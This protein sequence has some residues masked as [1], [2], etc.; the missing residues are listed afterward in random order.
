MIFGRCRCNCSSEEEG[1][2]IVFPA[3][4]SPPSLLPLGREGI[5]STLTFSSVS[6]LGGI[7]HGAW[8][9]YADGQVKE[10]IKDSL[11]DGIE[12]RNQKA[13]NSL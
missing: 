3:S 8:V 12:D 2:I 7:N 6:V 9:E 13:R 4:L 11:T 10:E 1:L 5:L